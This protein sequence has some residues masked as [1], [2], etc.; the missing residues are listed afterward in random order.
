MPTLGLAWF[1]SC[2]QLGTEH[3]GLPKASAPYS[4]ASTLFLKMKQGLGSPWAVTFGA[5]LPPKTH[6]KYVFMVSTEEEQ[7]ITEG[8]HPGS[9]ALRIFVVREEVTHHLSFPVSLPNCWRL[10]AV[11]ESSSKRGTMGV[12]CKSADLA[13]ARSG[14]GLTAT[15]RGDL[16]PLQQE[17]VRKLV[18]GRGKLLSLRLK[19]KF[20]GQAQGTLVV[21]SKGTAWPRSPG[22]KKH[23]RLHLSGY[24]RQH[25]VL[26][27]TSL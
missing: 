8:G 2:A 16:E 5:A 9:A 17:S 10:H 26:Q 24:S 25:E 22:R 20:P 21:F 1:L 4:Y 7:A 15:L 27:M 23:I 19:V 3:Q 14:A 18:V 13:C 12:Q 11:W 6:S